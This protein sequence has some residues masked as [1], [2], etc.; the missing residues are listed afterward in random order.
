[1]RGNSKK[2]L[3]A[4]LVTAVFTLCFFWS[5][6]V[7]AFAETQISTVKITA[8]KNNWEQTSNPEVK[9]VGNG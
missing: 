9:A 7:T 4:N 2:R 6:T 5:C 1:M 3:L 8:S